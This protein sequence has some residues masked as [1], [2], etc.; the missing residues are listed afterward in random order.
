M[1]R[2]RWGAGLRLGY[3]GSILGSPD[4]LAPWKSG[5][6][7]APCPGGETPGAITAFDLQRAVAEEG[8]VPQRAGHIERPLIEQRATVARD[9]GFPL[10]A[11]C[12]YRV[13]ASTSR[14]V[15]SDSAGWSLS[16]PRNE[17]SQT[18]R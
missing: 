11:I 8:L 2:E 10:C 12:F 5:T 18:L 9:A 15:G 16:P 13:F 1:S 17:L 3:Y 14:R 6:P 7:L 4:R